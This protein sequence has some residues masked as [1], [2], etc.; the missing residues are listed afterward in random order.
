[1]TFDPA[2]LTAPP[3]GSD[4][5]SDF[6]P[7]PDVPNGTGKTAVII[8]AGIG[9]LASA[10]HLAHAG[11]RVTV[12]ERH[13]I[14]GGRNGRWLSEGFTFDTGPSLLLMLEYWHKL[15]GMVGR[16]L[17]DYLDIVQVLPNYNVHFADGTVLE[18]TPQLN[19]LLEGMEKLE[20][21]CG[22]RVLE[23]LAR[24]KRMYDSGL[25]FISKNMTSPLDMV[26]PSRLGALANLGALGDLQK[27]IGK[28]VKDERLQ[29]ALS[30]QALY[31]GLSPYDALAIYALLPYTEIG[32]GVHYPM[33]GMHQIPLALEK[34]GREL[35]VQYRYGAK[36]ATLEK[37]ADT[38]T[39]ARLEDGTRIAG[40]VMLVNADLP[41]AYQ[42]LLGEPYPKIEQKRFS[43]SVVLMY[44]GVKKEFAN[45]EHHNFVVAKDMREA[46]RLLFEEHAMP[47]D[48]PYYVVATT[49]TDK[50]Q[51]PEGCENLFVLVLAPSQHPDPA[52]RI[53]WAVEGPIVEARMLEKLE[54]WA[55]PGLRENIVTKRLV[56]PDDF[57]AN[58]GNLRG[59][60]FG[61][62]HNLMQIGA[63][64]PQNRH[65]KYG[66][67]FFVGQS[68]HPG[69]GLPMALISAECVAERIVA[70]RP[71]AG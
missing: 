41:Y 70:E 16:K 54:Q 5:L 14:P 47:E 4:P 20:P 26:A 61:L 58:Y 12:L 35:G 69:C 24:T 27:L 6:P 64:R 46:C 53:D 37:T 18:M 60:A 68:T 13:A 1:M 8:G 39:A 29:Q 10:I 43:C 9:G 23:Y 71:A 59:E 33:G 32:G 7:P 51:A 65:P 62:A 28:Y 50:S 56:T 21:G 36:V 15:F 25:A 34:L 63:F 3:A 57:T 22:P 40:D 30:F 55:M 17:E 44:L 11:Y 19:V 52:K 49:R 66:N 48:T 31:L 42:A 2:T 45:L 38:V 67:L